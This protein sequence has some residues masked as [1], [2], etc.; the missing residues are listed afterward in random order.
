MMPFSLDKD[1]SQITEIVTGMGQ[2]IPQERLQQSTV[3]QAVDDDMPQIAKENS[4]IGEQQGHRST[5]SVKKKLR[6]DMKREE[7]GNRSAKAE[8]HRTVPISNS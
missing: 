2:R 1:V 7:G 3:D 5:K 4:E 8:E 6:A